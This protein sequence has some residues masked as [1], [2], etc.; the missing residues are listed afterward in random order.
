MNCLA[1]WFATARTDDKAARQQEHVIVL[2]GQE[3]L[4][5]PRI[6]MR[7]FNQMISATKINMVNVELRV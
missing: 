5:L 3:C 2:L 7:L 6:S 1:E 4:R